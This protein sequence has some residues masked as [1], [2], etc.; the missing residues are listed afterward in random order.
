MSG[1]SVEK[2]V[3]DARLRPADGILRAE[4]L[5]VIS[6]ARVLAERIVQEARE[7]AEDILSQARVQADALEQSAEEHVF[8]QAAELLAGLEEAGATVAERVAGT[9]VDLVVTLFDKL[10]VQTSAR[11]R[12]EASLK[13][14]QRETP[15]RLIDAVLRAHPEDIALLPA[16]AWEVKPDDTIARGACRL[17]ATSGEWHA[18][19]EAAVASLR[20]AFYDAVERSMEAQEIDG[21]Q[22]QDD[23]DEVEAD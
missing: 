8:A 18:D 6:D 17:E 1:F 4:A 22:D 21:D 11:K 20:N 19:F 12:I 5:T 3:T 13:R 10:L 9:V 23:R 7:Q 16:L 15:P 14:L 2:I